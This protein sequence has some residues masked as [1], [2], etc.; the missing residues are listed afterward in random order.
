MQV[1]K[2]YGPGTQEGGEGMVESCGVG[3]VV[4][5][6]NASPSVMESSDDVSLATPAVL[7]STNQL[8]FVLELVTL[9]GMKL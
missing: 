8:S 5:N 1:L 6:F 7:F 9:H 2:S 4:I 3:V